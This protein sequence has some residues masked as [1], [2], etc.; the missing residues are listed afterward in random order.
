M[1]Y[2]VSGATEPRILKIRSDSTRAEIDYQVAET[3]TY[4]LES[5]LDMT[6]WGTGLEDSSSG[7][8]TFVDQLAV[9]FEAPLQTRVF[10]RLRERP[11]E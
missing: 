5:G 10:Y 9:H 11:P 7:T 2:S 3:K 4:F 8:G 6:E 1:E